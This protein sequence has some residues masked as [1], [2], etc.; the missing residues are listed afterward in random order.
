MMIHSQMFLS[1][2]GTQTLK[3][4]LSDFLQQ[5]KALYSPAFR[6]KIS[7]SKLPE[8]ITKR[9][10]SQKRRLE[11][12]FVAFD[13]LRKAKTY[14]VFSEKKKEYEIIGESA[15]GKVVFIHVREE[16]SSQKDKILFF[17]SCYYRG[18]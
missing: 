14:T 15:E 12:V 5:K 8:A 6:R 16:E 13:I 4:R 11:C 7:L 9:K 17:V 3:K 10:E 2:V 18:K 1:H